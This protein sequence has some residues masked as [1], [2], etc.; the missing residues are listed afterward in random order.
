MGLPEPPELGASREQRFPE[1]LVGGIPGTRP[2]VREPVMRPL[3]PVRLARLCFIRH[4]YIK[5]GLTRGLLPA[6]IPHF[7]LQPIRLDPLGPPPAGR[8]QVHAFN[9]YV[10]VIGYEHAHRNLQFTAGD[11]R[12]PIC[13]R[14]DRD[15]G[16]Q[17]HGPGKPGNLFIQ[18][19]DRVRR[20]C[21]IPQ[22]PGHSEPLRKFGE[23]HGRIQRLILFQGVCHDH[24]EVLKPPDQVAG[25]P[26]FV[27]RNTVY[28]GIDP[29]KQARF[30]CA[31]IDIRMG[32]SQCRFLRSGQLQG[33]HLL[34]LLLAAAPHTDLEVRPSSHRVGHARIDGQAGRSHT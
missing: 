19:A 14:I 11:D 5:V 17:D 26:V 24:C 12:F 18:Q 15:A 20:R 8:L 23:H 13:E 33:S 2:V 3:Q 25:R 7:V 32:E 30:R 9:A 21:A 4:G 22:I 16:S 31:R 29:V 27:T 6:P 1:R 34:R 28:R 10:H